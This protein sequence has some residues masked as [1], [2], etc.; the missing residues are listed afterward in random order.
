MEQ[1]CRVADLLGGSNLPVDGKEVAPA[2]S[3]CPRGC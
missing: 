1:G 2:F 3:S